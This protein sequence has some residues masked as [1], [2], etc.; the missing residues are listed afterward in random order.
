MCTRELGSVSFELHRKEKRN[1]LN[2]SKAVF[3]RFFCPSMSSWVWVTWVCNNDSI[4]LFKQN[5]WGLLMNGL[6]QVLPKKCQRSA[7]AFVSEAPEMQVSYSPG[8][9]RSLAGAGRAAS[10]HVVCPLF[11]QGSLPF[12]RVPCLPGE[13]L[14]GRQSH[15]LIFSSWRPAGAQVMLY[16]PWGLLENA[17]MLFLLSMPLEFPILC[18]CGLKENRA[19]F[20]AWNRWQDLIKWW[21]FF[22]PFLLPNIC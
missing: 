19:S 15:G 5:L 17:F 9:G 7:V 1:I 20:L 22:L 13:K 18:M 16:T 21:D 3:L 6:F 10:C 8:A 4:R 12:P 14:D 2:Y 11:S